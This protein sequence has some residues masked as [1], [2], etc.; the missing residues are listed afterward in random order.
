MEH[1]TISY[2]I[3]N[4]TREIEIELTQTFPNGSEMWKPVNPVQALARIGHGT[5]L[6]KFGVRF[7]RNVNGQFSMARPC[8][9]NR[10]NTTVVRWNDIEDTDNRRSQ[11]SGQYTK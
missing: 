10:N 8:I 4:E 2:K 1:Q 6:W 3:G 5:K 9:N 7:V 11:H